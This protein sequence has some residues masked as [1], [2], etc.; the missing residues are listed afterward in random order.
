MDV[1]NQH[2]GFKSDITG[3]LHENSQQWDTINKMSDKLDKI[4]TSITNRINMILGGVVVA[5]IMLIL[6]F[7]IDK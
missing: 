7:F 5:C 1:C 3:L 6:N 4:Q 2:S